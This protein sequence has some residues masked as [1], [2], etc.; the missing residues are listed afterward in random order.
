MPPASPVLDLLVLK[1]DF[2]VKHLGKCLCLKK[3]VNTRSC[4]V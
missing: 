4:D 3:K 2:T 1:S